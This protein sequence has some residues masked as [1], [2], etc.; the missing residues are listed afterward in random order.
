[1]MYN[2]GNKKESYMLRFW[3]K[4]LTIALVLL[5]APLS[6]FAANQDILKQDVD[7]YLRDK[8]DYVLIEKLRVKSDKGESLK[9]YI[10]IYDGKKISDITVQDSQ[11]ND[12]DFSTSSQEGV[13]I[14]KVDELNSGANDITIRYLVDNGLDYFEKYDELDLVISSPRR[15]SPIGEVMTRVHF[16]EGKVVLSGLAK[17]EIS[18]EALDF[19]FSIS[20]SVYLFTGKEL[21]AHDQFRIIAGW[22]HGIINPS[23]EQSILAKRIYFALIYLMPIIYILFLGWSVLRYIL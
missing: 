9:R 21:K 15:A 14:I 3:L 11:S 7:V 20:D 23:V 8:G 2:L 17:Q 10:E 19:N 16:P 4:K 12:L 13:F 22:P 5:A 6:V 18:T 1:M